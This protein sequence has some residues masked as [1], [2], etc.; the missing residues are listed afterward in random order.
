MWVELFMQAFVISHGYKPCNIVANIEDTYTCTILVLQYD[1]I[2][3]S[4]GSRFTQTRLNKLTPSEYFYLR[5]DYNIRLGR[6]LELQSLELQ[7]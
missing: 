5:R 3:G 1:S 7:S 2:A 6:N 4:V